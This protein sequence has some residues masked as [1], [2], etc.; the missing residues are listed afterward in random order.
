[1]DGE[2]NMGY[3][4]NSELK[5]QAGAF[6]LF[7]AFALFAASLGGFTTTYFGTLGILDWLA[8]ANEQTNTIALMVSFLATGLNFVAFSG[9]IKLLPLYRT[10]K[11]KLLGVFVLVMLLGLSVSALTSTSIIGMTGTS[12]R[13]MYLMDEARRLG[14]QASGLSERSLSLKGFSDFI[15]P[16]AEVSCESAANERATGQLSGS[17]GKGVVSDSLQTL[18]TRKA[19]IAQALSDNISASAP[20]IA[21][22]AQLSRELDLLIID[23][24]VS[25]DAREITFIKHARELEA[26]ML[27][28]R[29]ADRTKVIRASYRAMKDAI[30]KIEDLGAN[31]SA[32]QAVALRALVAREQGSARAVEGYLAEI[33]ANALP[34][35]YRTELVP[36]P[37]LVLRYAPDH[38]PQFALA[39]LIDA[40]GPMVALLSWAAAMRRRPV[41][42]I[43]L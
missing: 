17:A 5:A 42:K 3:D 12:A 35:P 10:G 30:E 31:V 25:I 13:A 16:D 41:R 1:M 6:F 40:F 29:A 22:I 8:G 28:L 18:C 11:A 26:R 43:N 9:T 19:G 23:K 39:L 21:E 38:S 15:G 36:M 32:G 4:P 20:L 24:S 7:A 27:D 2:E 37:R 14:L 33:E 34:S